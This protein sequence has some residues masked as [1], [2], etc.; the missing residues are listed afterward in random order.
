MDAVPRHLTLAT[1]LRHRHL[2]PS[3]R[4]GPA[5]HVISRSQMLHGT[6]LGM[7]PTSFRNSIASSWRMKSDVRNVL[8]GAPSL[9]SNRRPYDNLG[10]NCIS[11]NRSSYWATVFCICWTIFCSPNTIHRKHVKKNTSTTLPKQKAHTIEQTQ[12]SMKLTT[13]KM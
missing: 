2:N 6:V 12:K 13:T 8:L 3:L 9:R 1:L 7:R 10:I 11:R 5:V 4:V